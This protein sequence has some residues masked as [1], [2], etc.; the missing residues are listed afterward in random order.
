M[1]SPVEARVASG[2]KQLV[3][4]LTARAASGLKQ[5]VLDLTARALQWRATQSQIP[6]LSADSLPAV[7]IYL[8]TLTDKH[9]GGWKEFWTLNIIHANH[10]VA[11]L[12]EETL[13]LAAEDTIFALCSLLE[14]LAFGFWSVC[15]GF[16][17]WAVADCRP[18]IP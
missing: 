6:R 4:D 2:L 5:L 8:V 18:C 3:G 9:F 12:E 1:V 15:F 17:L 11:V 7:R 14:N 13:F 10:T 16:V